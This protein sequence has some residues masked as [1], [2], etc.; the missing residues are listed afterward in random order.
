MLQDATSF[1][2]FSSCFSSDT[3]PPSFNDPIPDI[4]SRFP[5]LQMVLLKI[6]VIG[7]ANVGKSC[8]VLRCVLII[9]I[10]FDEN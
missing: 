9:V 6:I 8:L 10:T 4:Q 5:P 1:F 7:D 2:V 3:A